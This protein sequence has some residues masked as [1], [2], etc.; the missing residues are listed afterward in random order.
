MIVGPKQNAGSLLTNVCDTVFSAVSH[1]T[2]GFALIGG[3][4]S[5]ATLKKYLSKVTLHFVWGHLLRKQTVGL[6]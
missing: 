4:S 3:N 2:L 6:G 5:T 1:G